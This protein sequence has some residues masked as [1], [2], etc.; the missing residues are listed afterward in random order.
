[1]ARGFSVRRSNSV[2]AVM[3]RGHR[4]KE[5]IVSCRERHPPQPR[6]MRVTFDP[7]R[8]SLAWIAQAY[9]QV[10]PI[11]RRTPTRSSRRNHWQ[12]EEVEQPS[13][14]GVSTSSG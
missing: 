6:E 10:V 5:M 11:V 4:D 1:M 8:L 12:G 2:C 13:S 9:E 7:S 14:P 3:L